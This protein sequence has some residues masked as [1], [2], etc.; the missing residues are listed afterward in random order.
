MISSRRVN[1]VSVDV[2]M[3]YLAVLVVGAVSNRRID[4]T[5]Y[6]IIVGAV[7]F[8]AGAVS[9]IACADVLM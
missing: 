4:V 1:I 6:I 2:L 8:K 3:V 5:I 9:N 7:G